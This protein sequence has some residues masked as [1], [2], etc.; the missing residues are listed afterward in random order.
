MQSL[1]AN[2]AS[3]T[4][5]AL[6][7]SHHSLG[8]IQNQLDANIQALR[9]VVFRDSFYISQR[10]ALEVAFKEGPRLVH[11]NLDNL[12]CED[13]DLKDLAL[14]CP[15]I[16]DL[17]LKNS[18]ITT[19]QPFLGMRKL[20]S[21]DLRG[22][23]RCEDS[24]LLSANPLCTIVENK[25]LD[26]QDIDENTL[27]IA[28]ET[29]TKTQN[30]PWK[31]ENG[32]LSCATDL[33][34]LPT[35]GH[36]YQKTAAI[37]SRR[38]QEITGI[39]L[40]T[41]SPYLKDPQSRK[42]SVRIIDA[43]QIRKLA[44]LVDPRFILLDKTKYP[45][46]L[47]SIA[48]TLCVMIP[49]GYSKKKLEENAPSPDIKLPFPLI[50][51]SQEG[52]SIKLPENLPAEF[53][54]S[55]QAIVGKEPVR[56]AEINYGKNYSVKFTLPLAEV[57]AFLCDKLGLMTVP[58]PQSKLTDIIEDIIRARVGTKGELTEAAKKI[59]RG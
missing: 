10:Q 6:Q 38:F 19:V 12:F 58:Y 26:L 9:D 40:K 21:L 36:L 13:H 4:S 53:S 24:A 15:N 29:L 55:L 11:L 22:S 23:P 18:R 59:L 31:I 52:L 49:E 2:S 8:A 35:E 33:V 34:V 57:R 27:R 56:I 5:P 44:D 43:E 16:Q 17:S 45:R 46:S 42:V 20:E 37:F 7:F 39:K 14:V 54:T 28:L 51:I 32:Y 25:S 48:A 41:I 47:T 50:D 1:G 30:F 3:E